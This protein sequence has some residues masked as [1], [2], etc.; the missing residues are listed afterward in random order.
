MLKFIH[1]YNY[2]TLQKGGSYIGYS[3]KFLDLFAGIGG[4]SLGLEC[5]GMECIGQ[6]EIDP[7]CNKILE[8]HWP[9]VKRLLDI[10][11]IKGNEFEKVDLICGGFPCQPFSVAGKQRGK[12]DDRYLWPEML[13]VIKLYKPAWCIIENV[14]GF[15]RMGLDTTLFDLESA[16][17]TC[18][19]FNI[20]ACA[21]NAPH[22][23]KRIW[24]MAYSSTQRLQRPI[25]EG[26]KSIQNQ[27]EILQGREF[28][29]RNTKT[30]EYWKIKPDVGR[31][32][33]GVPF[34]VDRLKCLGNA[35]V[36]QIPEIFGGMILQIENNLT[37]Q[38]GGSHMAIVLNFKDFSVSSGSGK[39]A[40]DSPEA[41]GEACTLTQLNRFA[42]SILGA[43]FEKGTKK[44][45][46]CKKVY[47]G[48]VKE[49][50]KEPPPDLDKFEQSKPST[51]GANIS[52]G[53]SSAGVKISSEDIATKRTR[54]TRKKTGVDSYE[55][56]VER[57]NKKYTE[58]LENLSL[59][60]EYTSDYRA[61]IARIKES[62]KT[63]IE[64]VKNLRIYL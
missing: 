10:K 22:Q 17:Y 31:V 23:R 44:N 54:K 57:I 36:P 37:L 35:V 29:R 12:K 58:I 49:C 52:G 6:V 53:A 15:V 21:I 60:K 63:E 56:I 26:F 62:Q 33:D 59:V 8:K 43:R 42:E 48:M 14:T 34:R 51:A 7:Y 64:A 4:F 45:E 32:A 38:K 18:Q 27:V 55:S 28:S 3:F 11:N 41:L 16:G 1:Q 39:N 20:P 40:I 2:L 46:A 9:D 24:I 19:T 30:R 25:Q 13:R 5:A 47:G 61:V 50:G